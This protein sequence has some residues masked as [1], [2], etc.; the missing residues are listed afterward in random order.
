MRI[1]Q[2][3]R[4]AAE[5]LRSRFGHGVR[6]VGNHTTP[7]KSL[8]A[9]SKRK[10]VAETMGNDASQDISVPSEVLVAEKPDKIDATTQTEPWEHDGFD[11]G[12]KPRWL[13]LFTTKKGRVVSSREEENMQSCCFSVVSVVSKFLNKM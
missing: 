11:M 1:E 9:F 5:R 8:V 3:A 4:L 12:H 10:G 13:H 7:P 2:T 6:L